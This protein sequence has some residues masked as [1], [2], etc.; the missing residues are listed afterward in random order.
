MGHITE[1]I[2]LRL[3]R[4]E[5]FALDDLAEA[6]M[7]R[8]ASNR[9][10]LAKYAKGGGDLRTAASACDKLRGAVFQESKESDA[11][12]WANLI[13]RVPDKSRTLL[14]NHDGLSVEAAF[15]KYASL[16]GDE[17]IGLVIEDGIAVEFAETL[18]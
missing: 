17:K 16:P 9:N 18:K 3:T 13:K 8:L 10:A 1:I 4:E 2:V 15:D 14:G 12:L 6:A 5:A 11:L 7:D